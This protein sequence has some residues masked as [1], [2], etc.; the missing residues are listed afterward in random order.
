[1]AFATEADPL[2]GDDFEWPHVDLLIPTYNEPLS[3]VR[4]TALAALNIDYPPDKLH[5]Y[6]LDNGTGKSSPVLSEAGVGYVT[7][8]KHS[9]A[10]AGNIKIHADH[11]EL[12]VRGDLRLRSR[13][14]TGFCR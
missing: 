2:P 11:D 9:H 7:R 4:Y 5:V 13:A 8:E 10:K 14:H 3:L 1:M 6:I 12:A